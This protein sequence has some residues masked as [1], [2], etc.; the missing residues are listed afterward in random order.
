[1]FK[2]TE[3][4]K[5]AERELDLLLEDERERNKQRPIG[6]LESEYARFGNKTPQE[7]INEEVLKIMSMIN[8]EL[9]STK[10]I[11]HVLDIVYRLAQLENLLPLTLKDD[12]FIKVIEEQDGDT[13]Y[14]NVRNIKVFKN[15]KRGIYHL[16]GKA[17][18]NLA[19][20]NFDGEEKPQAGDV[21]LSIFDFDE[22]KDK[23]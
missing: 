7:F 16:D 1:M 10:S 11:S 19:T 9:H 14:Q 23:Q 17:A 22:V 6:E 8:P 18:L 4:Y 21:Q 2:D 15:N 12:E 13:L 20:G 5:H 3:L